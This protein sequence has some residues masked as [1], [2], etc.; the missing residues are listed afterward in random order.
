MIF[1]PFISSIIILGSSVL[2]NAPVVQNFV[3]LFYIVAFLLVDFIFYLLIKFVV[4]K[5]GAGELYSGIKTAVMIAAGG[6]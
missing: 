6:L 2:I 1:I 5:T 4:N 3:I